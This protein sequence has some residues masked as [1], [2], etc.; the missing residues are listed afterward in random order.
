MVAESTSSLHTLGEHTDLKG[1]TVLVR[2]GIDVPLKEDGT[3]VDDFRLRKALPTLQLLRAAGARTIVIGHAS[4]ADGTADA[5]MKP[6]CDLLNTYIPITWAGGILGEAVLAQ[7][8][9]LKDGELLML[10]NLRFDEGEKGNSE[11]FARAL[12]SYADLYVNDAFS[13]AHRTHASVVG[14]P[15]YLPSCAG[16]LFM[17]EF[18]HLKRARTP[19]AP[20]LLVLGG[21]KFETKL[22]LVEAL[23]PHYD[24]IFIGGALANNFFRERGFEVGDSLVSAID[25]T[26][27]ALFGNPKLLLPI[28]VVVRTPGGKVV[29]HPD[30]IAKGEAVLDAGPETLEMLKEE[31]RFMKTV[32]WNGPLGDYERGFDEGTRGFASLVAGSDAVSIVGGGDTVASVKDPAVT[33]R[34]TFLSTAGG[35][36]LAFLERGTL[37]GIEALQAAPTT[38]SL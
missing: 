3:I 19:E 18:N 4:R 14:I 35:A 27:T 6:I 28:D 23:M 37:P 2:A 32:L 21:S 12:A 15:Q 10:E 34:F 25:V 26:T 16:E 9:A 7:V 17:D 22:P 31:L 1:L 11:T 36:M 8:K 29:K 13:V 30:M 38:K 33:E 20:A 24:R 5:T